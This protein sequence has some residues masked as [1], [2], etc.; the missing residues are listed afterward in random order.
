MPVACILKYV[1]EET[2]LNRSRMIL[3]RLFTPVTILMVP[4]SRTRP[5]SIR[6]PV[7]AVV[8]SVC[9]FLIGTSFVAAVSVRAVEYR[10]MQERL[11]YLS[12]QFHEMKGVMLSL[13]QAEKD[14]RTLFNVKSKTAVLESADL[15][16]TGS[17][18]MEM[19]R[20]QIA[21]SM[22]SVTDI[23]TYI[24]EQKDLYR[25]TP[26]GWPVSGS[27][28]SPYGNRRH[29]VHDET[30]FH[31]G[32]DISVPSGSEVKAT[33]DGIVSFAG[34]TETSGIVVV[35]EHGH[36]FSTAYAHSR[37]AMVRVGQRVA[38]GE[39]IALSGSTGVS[40]GPH[41]HYEI[42]K[43]GRHTNPADFLARR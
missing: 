7:L 38:R 28:S 25:A 22:R 39:P 3:K 34:W 21:A 12:S 2:G 24:A 35:V 20:E 30:R 41:V 32:V 8:A 18:D 6:V 17:L 42:W 9:L 14:F 43:N 11:S 29:P 31:T 37:K 36:G 4:H 10:R 5:V 40:T 23:R 33:A 15:A 13:R 27:L 26:T 1:T 16:D 19:L